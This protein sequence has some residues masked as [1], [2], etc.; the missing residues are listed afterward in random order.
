[1]HPE[2]GAVADAAARLTQ[3]LGSA[4]PTALVLGSGLGGFLE[5]LSDVQRIDSAQVGLPQ[6]AVAGHAGLVARGALAGREVAVFAGRVH[7]Y[8]GGSAAEVVRYVRVAHRW[9]I[10]RLILTNS[11][12]GITDG[13][14]PGH[15]VV[16][17]DHLNLQ[18]TNPLAGPAFATRFPDLGSAYDPELRGHLAAAGEAAGATVHHGVL[19]AM[20]GPSYETPAEI[21]MLAALGADVVGMSTVPEVLAAA[22]L[23]LPCA[24]LSMVSNRAAGLSETALSHAEVTE[25]AARGASIL[26]ATL[27]GAICAMS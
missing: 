4:P 6:P 16:I 17:T 11:V 22:E 25:T 15:L 1:M 24:A 27:T 9:G 20:L 26:A 5:G 18:G 23:G 19:A 8:E 14:D 3:H 2:E 10:E 13:F 21:R 12:G 7:L